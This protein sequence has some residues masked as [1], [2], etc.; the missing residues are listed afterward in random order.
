MISAKERPRLQAEVTASSIPGASMM[1]EKTGRNG[2]TRAHR[3]LSLGA[4]ASCECY[5][6]KKTRLQ[7]EDI[8]EGNQDGRNSFLP[9]RHGRIGRCAKCAG[10]FYQEGG[11]HR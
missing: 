8:H 5:L 1:V 10:N 3:R 2:I 4:K 7:V 11:W 9:G 6:C